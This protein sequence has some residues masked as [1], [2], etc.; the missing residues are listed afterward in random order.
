VAKTDK[1][2]EIEPKG[3]FIK[4]NY[5]KKKILNLILN[6]Q[7]VNLLIYRFQSILLIF[8]IKVVIDEHNNF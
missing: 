6:L 2:S 7:T 4:R 5:P 8:F 1:I 3:S